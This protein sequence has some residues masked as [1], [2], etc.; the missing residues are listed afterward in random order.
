MFNL[1]KDSGILW[2]P[3]IGDRVPRM[4]RQQ[5]TVCDGSALRGGRPERKPPCAQL[6][7]GAR[8]RGQVGEPRD[9]QLAAHA[10]LGY[11]I[12]SSEKARCSASPLLVAL[13][14]N[15]SRTQ[16]RAAAAG[17]SF[18]SP[19]AIKVP[20]LETLRLGLRT[21]SARTRV[22]EPS[23][24]ADSAQEAGIEA[25]DYEVVRMTANNIKLEGRIPPI[26]IAACLSTS[27]SNRT[28]VESYRDCCRG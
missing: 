6:S 2:W 3:R 4:L 27:G 1:R 13:I 21:T 18:I 8:H 25:L 20:A 19:T 12:R 7:R 15:T 26:R 17:A 22:D 23:R 11:R 16:N 10:G 5:S 28:A 24:D 14:D 9:E